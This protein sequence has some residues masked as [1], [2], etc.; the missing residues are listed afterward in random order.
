MKNRR[1]EKCRR[2]TER[3]YIAYL[4]TLGVFKVMQ[5]SVSIYTCIHTHIHMNACI[6]A[7]VCRHKYI[8]NVYI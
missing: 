7:G 5:S 1:K 8:D 2:E 6:Y 4:T 3:Y